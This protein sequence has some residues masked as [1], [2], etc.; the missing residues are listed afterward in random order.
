M[1][2]LP[3]LPAPRIKARIL[4]RQVINLRID[5]DG[6]LFHGLADLGVRLL[7]KTHVV[8]LM[9]TVNDTLRTD[10]TRIAV[11]AE[12]LNLLLRMV[13]AEVT[14]RPIRLVDTGS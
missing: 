2:L 13:F 14:H 5:L 6:E 9:R 7:Q 11:K 3:N 8:T 12:I 10:W 1:I 4:Q